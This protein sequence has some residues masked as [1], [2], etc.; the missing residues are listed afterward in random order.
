[1]TIPPL[2]FRN[3][4]LVFCSWPASAR[5][6]CENSNHRGKRSPAPRFDPLSFAP[7]QNPIPPGGAGSRPQGQSLPNTRPT[8]CLIPAQA[9][10]LGH[11]P[12][13]PVQA[14]GLLHPPPFLSLLPVKYPFFVSLAI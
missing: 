5:A 2:M 14:N 1:M 13:N 6:H 11:P 8:A 12:I 4:P 10:G 3:L 7:D 9:N